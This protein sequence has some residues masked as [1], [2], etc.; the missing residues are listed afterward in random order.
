MRHSADFTDCHCECATA[1]ALAEWSVRLL[2]QRAAFLAIHQDAAQQLPWCQLM[3]AS[4]DACPAA[5]RVTRQPPHATSSGV[6]EAWQHLPPT[7]LIPDRQRL[8]SRACTVAYS[9]QQVRKKTK[10]VH[11]LHRL[12]LE[13]SEGVTSAS[14][15]CAVHIANLPGRKMWQAG[16]RVTEVSGRNQATQVQGSWEKTSFETHSAKFS[17]FRLFLERNSLFVFQ[18]TSRFRQRSPKLRSIQFES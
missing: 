2:Q 11:L 3:P 7:A 17:S 16:N 13:A 9:D 12:S 4:P 6:G 1:P 14:V 18:G 15:C 5:D 10:M 8:I